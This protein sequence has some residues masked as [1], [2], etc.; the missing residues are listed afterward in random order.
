M[1]NIFI[2]GQ[3]VIYI[4]VTFRLVS[5]PEAHVTKEDTTDKYRAPALDKGLDILELLAVQ[6]GGMT[7]GEIVKA[8]GRGPSEIYRMLERLVVRGYV[9]RS[10]EGD[11]FAL[12][13]K[14]FQMGSSFPPIRRLVAQAQPMMDR[15]TQDTN[16]S[17]HLVMPEMGQSYVMAQASSQKV[18]EFRLRLGAKLDLF[19]TGSGRVLLAFMPEEH[20]AHAF[21]LHPGEN[22]QDVLEELTQIRA[23]GHRIRPSQQLVGVTDITVPILAPNNTAAGVL[24]CPFLRMHHAEEKETDAQI[25]FCLQK[26]LDAAAHISSK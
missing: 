12:T 26:L 6:P 21:D 15:F 9:G 1:I 24:T 7:R 5:I 13:T 22:V 18:W 10:L 17:V 16:Q 4:P 19:D 20:R 3:E 2:F 14:L 25:A 11:R 8:L 23:D